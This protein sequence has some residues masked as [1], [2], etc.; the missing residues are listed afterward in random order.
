M[1]SHKDCHKYPKINPYAVT[2]ME[3]I[4]KDIPNSL[5]DDLSKRLV[6]IVLE[7]RDR[8]AVPA[9]LAKKIIYL[10]RQDQLTSK[11]GIATMLEA[12]MVVDAEATVKI[13]GE[14]GLQEVVFALKSLQG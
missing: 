12:A 14:F 13:L 5:Y 2:D 4:V 7:T 11:T 6:G 3:T 8:D 10:W 1:S 9:E